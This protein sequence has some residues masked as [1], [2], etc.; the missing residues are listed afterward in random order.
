M[1][2]LPLG[3]QPPDLIPDILFEDPHLLVL[4]KPAGL[5]SQGGPEGEF[6]LVDWLRGYLGRPYVGLI[7]RLDRNT[8][9]I[10]IV[11]KRSKAATR[12]TSSLQ[13]GKIYR[14]YL[15]WIEGTITEPL[16]LHH[17]VT[18]NAQTNLSRAWDTP[19][20]HAKEAILHLRPK[21]TTQWHGKAFSLVTFELETGRSHQIRVQAAA[22]GHPLLGDKKYGTGFGFPR[23]ALHSHRLEFDHPKAPHERLQ[24]EVPLPKDMSKLFG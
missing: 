15:A 12:L 21:Q 6:N 19:R 10:M 11:A 3:K 20:A 13:A 1:K 7:H 22:I 8:S 9:G 5:L 4:D 23:P 2:N 18:K 14:S 16:Q 24:F 17:W